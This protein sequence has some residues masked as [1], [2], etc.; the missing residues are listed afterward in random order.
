MYHTI[1]LHTVDAT[2]QRDMSKTVPRSSDLGLDLMANLATR[3]FVVFQIRSGHTDQLIQ[4]TST[5]IDLPRESIP[6]YTQT[7][8]PLPHHP[9]PTSKTTPRSVTTPIP[10][11]PATSYL[12]KCTHVIGVS[13]SN[14]DMQRLRAS[15]VLWYVFAHRLDVCPCAAVSWSVCGSMS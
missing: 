2:C 1:R 7:C 9:Q 14:C 10:K 6:H 8:G 4:N 12:C 11:V 13:V 15:D 3:N 5:H